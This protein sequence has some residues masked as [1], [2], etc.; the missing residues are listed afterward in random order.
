MGL[1]A[2]GSRDVARHKRG[3]AIQQRGYEGA[4]GGPNWAM[5]RWAAGLLVGPAVG[6]CIRLNNGS[7]VWALPWAQ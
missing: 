1:I 6:P 2:I 4:D 3:K 5:R 7:L